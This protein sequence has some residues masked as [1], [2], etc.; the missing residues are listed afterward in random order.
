MSLQL[1]SVANRSD[2]VEVLTDVRL[3]LNIVDCICFD[4]G[5]LRLVAYVGE[6]QL[7]SITE[8]IIKDL[9]EPYSIYTYRYFLHA[10]PQLCFLVCAML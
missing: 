5:D 1:Q 10:W 8:L 4:S 3:N 6:E 2:Q 7:P 9:S